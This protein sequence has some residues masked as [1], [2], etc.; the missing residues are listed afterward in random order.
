M[1]RAFSTS[2]DGQE[3]GRSM[4]DLRRVAL[5]K[6]HS[7]NWSALWFSG[8]RD[9]ARVGITCNSQPPSA[10]M[11]AVQVLHVSLRKW[12]RSFTTDK[13]IPLPSL[14]HTTLL[15]NY[16]TYRSLHLAFPAS[17]RFQVGAKHCAITSRDN[18]F[19][20]VV[21]GD[22]LTRLPQSPDYRCRI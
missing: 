3:I 4:E 14:P 15:E 7:M 18:I 17:T 1:E 8:Q 19:E 21:S 16:Q 6:F 10:E 11:H 5:P 9:R 20:K 13:S 22:L 12:G 2:S